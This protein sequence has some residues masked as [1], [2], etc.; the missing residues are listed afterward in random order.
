MI[1]STDNECAYGTGT[2]SF[3]PAN[4]VDGVITSTGTIDLPLLPDFLVDQRSK[5]ATEPSREP[6]AAVRRRRRDSAVH[7]RSTVP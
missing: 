5:A 6:M 3:A 1:M 4:L 7:E 2:C